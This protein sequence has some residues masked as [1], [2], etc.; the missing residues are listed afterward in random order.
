M[1]RGVA[2]GG[3]LTGVLP[4]VDVQTNNCRPPLGVSRNGTPPSGPIWPVLPGPL[5]L[6][7]SLRGVFADPAHHGVM[8]VNWLIAPI[9]TQLL[10][11]T[12]MGGR[13]RVNPQAP[14]LSMC[15]SFLSRSLLL[16]SSFGWSSRFVLSAYVSGGCRAQR[17]SAQMA[18]FEHCGDP[19][20]VDRGQL[21]PSV[22]GDL[23]GPPVPG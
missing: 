13:Q 14:K 20:K 19:S 1:I 17:K 8:S 10:G 12:P 11:R 4:Q 23:M 16:R 3:V 18:G 21:P 15:V 9:G 7:G 6:F 5:V 2:S 22:V